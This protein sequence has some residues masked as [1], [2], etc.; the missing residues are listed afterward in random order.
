[1]N[2]S[3]SQT[4]QDN[5]EL[6]TSIAKSV[7]GID[8]CIM[9]EITHDQKTEMTVAWYMDDLKVSQKDS[10]K[11]TKLEKWLSRIH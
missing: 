10:W 1:M 11:I 5:I 4:I 8:L 9:A 6:G 3:L 7:E 2:Q